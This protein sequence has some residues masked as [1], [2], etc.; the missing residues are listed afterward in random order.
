M[1]GLLSSGLST[2]FWLGLA[3]MFF[4]SDFLFSVQL[5]LGL[6]VFSGFLLADTQLI[7][8]KAMLGSNDHV[9]HALQLFTDVVGIFIRLMII[10]ARNREREQ[11]RRRRK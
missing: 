10:I 11:D 6:M 9:G 7:V 1:A 4:L 3:N 5:Y 2:L 8:H